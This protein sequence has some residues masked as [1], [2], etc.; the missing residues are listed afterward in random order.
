MKRYSISAAVNSVL[1]N[2][3]IMQKSMDNV[4]GLYGIVMKEVEKALIE[5]ILDVTRHNKRKTAKILGISR[6]TLSS[7]IDTLGLIED[8]KF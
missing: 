4:S 3:I 6:N 8:N 7:K 2:Y 1:E 5:K